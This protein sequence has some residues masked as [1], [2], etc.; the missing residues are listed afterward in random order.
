[1]NSSIRNRLASMLAISTALVGYGLV[2]APSAS[3]A[4][5]GCAGS[6]I[7]SFAVKSQQGTTFGHIYLYFDSSTKKNCAVTVKNDA[8][9]YGTVT[10]TSIHIWKCSAG[11]RAGSD[12]SN[13]DSDVK[14]AGDYKYQAGPKSLAA[15]GH[16]IEVDATINNK[17][18]Y[19]AQ[20]FS[21]AIHCG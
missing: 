13:I 2:T 9:S 14:D 11:T 19:T 21:K 15:G 5:Y 12:C 1:M 4:N 6:S 18:G 7:D 3:A 17:Y 16:C 8:G 20:Y 10:Y